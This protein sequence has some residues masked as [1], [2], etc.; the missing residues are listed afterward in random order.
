MGLGVT[1][2]Q[3]FRLGIRRY[4]PDEKK[5]TENP[6]MDLCWFPRPYASV[7]PPH[8]RTRAHT[9]S[10]SSYPATA[11]RAGWPGPAPAPT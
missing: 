2:K 8:A 3:S 4:N 6:D 11:V 7:R 1:A 9:H 10:P 5:L